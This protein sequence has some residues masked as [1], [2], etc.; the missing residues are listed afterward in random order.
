MADK[1]FK[2]SAEYSSM[3]QCAGQTPFSLAALKQWKKAGAP[4][5][6]HG[7]VQFWPLLDWVLNGD[8]SETDAPLLTNSHLVDAKAKRERLALARDEKAVISRDDAR[9][10]A[11]MAT[12]DFFGEM[13]RF[14]IADAPAALKGMSEGQIIAKARPLI[15]ELKRKFRETILKPTE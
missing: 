9:R 1:R 8:S 6:D 2:F 4:G 7:R 3:A 10:G 15:E 11:E 14:W 12:A 13:E 5:F